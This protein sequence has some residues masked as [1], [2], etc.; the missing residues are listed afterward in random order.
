M[1]LFNNSKTDQYIHANQNEPDKSS[2]L[3]NVTAS[4]DAKKYRKKYKC[5]L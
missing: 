5:E 2:A 1:W 3:V 4:H